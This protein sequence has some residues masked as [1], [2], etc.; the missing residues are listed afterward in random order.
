MLRSRRYKKIENHIQRTHTLSALSIY[1]KEVMYGAVDG[2]ITTFAIV[3]GFSGAALS[4]E[5]TT[6]L[7]FMVVLLFGFANLFGDGVSMG[8]GNFLAVRSE[9][10]LY[11]SIWK[12]EQ[13]AS[14]ENG[15][16]EARETK[17]SLIH[18]GFSEE[19]AEILTNIYRKNER[20][21]V[22]FIVNNELK[23]A[24]PMNESALY[25]GVATFSA[26]V[27]F[28]LIPLIPFMVMGGS[29]SKVVFL[30]S[31]LSALAALVL[32]GI[33]KWRIV[34]TH[35]LRSVFEVVIVG[36]IA[37]SVSFFIGSLFSM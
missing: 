29:D 19:D 9:Q 22:D 11:R 28:G 33:L 3:A 25:T 14:E 27:F 10:G 36:T 20:Y 26:F 7:S 15:G 16:A 30:S 6:Q 32:L 23:I 24:N 13:D 21:W 2:I 34:K 37:A 5:T 31:G 17:I 12:R 4:N 8:L 1:L 35:L 18:K